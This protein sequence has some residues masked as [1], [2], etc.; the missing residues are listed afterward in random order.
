MNFIR[1]ITNSDVLADIIDIPKELRNRKVEIIILPYENENN[2]D[3]FK[4]K[5]LRGALAKYKNE[6]LQ[7]KENEAWISA[8]AEKYENS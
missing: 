8:V 7:K 2:S 5:S 6:E 1:K 4:K 3:I